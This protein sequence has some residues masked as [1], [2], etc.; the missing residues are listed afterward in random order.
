MFVFPLRNV[1]F[2][3][4]SITIFDGVSL[5]DVP[6][7]QVDGDSL[8]PTL[9]DLTA[10]AALLS[11]VPC[12]KVRGI[13]LMEMGEAIEL[14]ASSAI[15]LAKIVIQL[16]HVEGIF[17]I[18]ARS[19]PAPRSAVYLTPA[20]LGQMSNKFTLPPVFANA[21]PNNTLRQL[22]L[23]SALTTTSA[24]RFERIGQVLALDA[25]RRDAK[26]PSSK[27]KDAL[28]Q[29]RLIQHC[30]RIATASEWLFDAVNDSPSATA[31]VQLAIGFET[32]Y[33]G[34]STDPVKQTLS[35]RVAY[36]LGKNPGER[37]DLA[38]K[39]VEFYTSRSKVVHTGV[40]SLNVEQRRQFEFGKEL[41][42][43]CLRHELS[44]IPSVE[45]PPV[46]ELLQKLLP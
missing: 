45:P 18:N 2:L 34:E 16:A 22:P 37:Q 9:A 13:G 31:F 26:Q 12:L 38:E 1:Q 43:R 19:S 32:L 44:L 7:S 6:R 35:N 24:K 46:S 20:G 5:E 41:L 40:S 33:G 30:A 8:Q 17:G 10:G 39:F 4:D 21:L 36:S 27:D 11:S 28:A 14:P 29:Y 3:A 42:N 25:K 23:G 15:R